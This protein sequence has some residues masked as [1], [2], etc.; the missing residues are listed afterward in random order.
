MNEQRKRP[1]L[2]HQVNR[3][4]DF[5]CERELGHTGGHRDPGTGKV[6]GS[7]KLPYGMRGAKA[8]RKRKTK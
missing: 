1:C 2:A 8:A 6:W 7:P 3:Q 4:P 5:F